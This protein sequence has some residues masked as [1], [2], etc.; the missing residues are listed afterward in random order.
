MVAAAPIRRTLALVAL[1]ALFAL[2]R[3]PAAS[4]QLALQRSP[5]G[6]L[7]CA[8]LKRC[9]DDADCATRPGTACRELALPVGSSVPPGRFCVDPEGTRFCCATSV[10][11]PVRD[12]VRS[13]C[14][15]PPSMTLDTGVCAYG[16]EIDF[17]FCGRSA[18]TLMRSLA[19]LVRDCFT[20]PTDT[21]TPFGTTRF[22]GGDCD[23]DG[24]TN[25]ADPCPCSPTNA[26]ERADAGAPDDDAGTVDA[27]AGTPE[28]DAGTPEP[29]AGATDLGV[30]TPPF[31]A[32]VTRGPA[33][34]GGGGCACRTVPSADPTGL[35]LAALFGVL[36]V[37]L[38]A[39]RRPTR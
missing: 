24:L 17:D 21:M 5:E 14:I 38:R 29:D 7:T 6:R 23:G 22:A 34:R 13:M 1:G 18:G 8:M 30:V 31:D 32:A 27:D 28:T 37:A 15:N 3:V 10:D 4:A 2:V 33:F 35:P 12:G 20:A 19:E 26:C 11:C 9:M 36:S 16:D 25:A 39:R